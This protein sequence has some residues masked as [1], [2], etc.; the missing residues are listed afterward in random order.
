MMVQSGTTRCVFQSRISSIAVHRAGIEAHV[1]ERDP[2]P[3]DSPETLQA[4]VVLPDRF[5]TT[6]VRAS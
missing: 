5:R 6:D 2:I 3:A 4:S 1:D